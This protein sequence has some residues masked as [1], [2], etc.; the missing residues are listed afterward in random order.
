MKKLKIGDVVEG[1]IILISDEFIFIDI[2]V[3]TDGIL[4]I[5]SLS[6][7]INVKNLKIGDKITANINK[8]SYDSIELT[9]VLNKKEG[10]LNELKNAYENKIPIKGKIANSVNGGFKVNIMG[11]T[12]FCP[13]SHIDL[14]HIDNVEP[15]INKEFL[16]QIIDFDPSSNKIVVSRKEIL[17][18]EQLSI[19]QK[20][21]EE[22]ETNSDLII[23]GKI[24]KEVNNGYLVELENK[25][26]AYLP[27]HELNSKEKI[28]YN[29]SLQFKIKNMK[30]E[31]DRIYVL[32]TLNFLAN[33]DWGESLK[34]FKIGDIVQGQI[35]NVIKGG[36]IIEI[37]DNLNG[38][39]PNHEIDKNP[40]ISIKE[41]QL[42]SLLDVEIKDIEY[43]K[44]QIIL[45][46]PENKEDWQQYIAKNE[47]KYN[48]FAEYFKKRS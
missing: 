5:R 15:F 35:K 20:L 1:E 17:K 3:K 23:N 16:F 2:G 27:Q 14:Y 12:A 44:K 26:M 10:H 8:I 40:Q 37:D 7:N 30:I 21:K 33:K 4:P 39:L 42:Y 25:L 36:Y 31:K 38:F 19:W 34:K 13:I 46:I 11:K 32:L 45:K 24:K 48:P 18:K 22:W 28:N 43:F 9:Q 47:K 29:A 6:P 41:L